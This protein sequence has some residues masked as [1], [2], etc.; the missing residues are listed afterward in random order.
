MTVQFTVLAEAFNGLSVG[1]EPREL[2][3]AISQAFSILSTESFGGG[4]TIINDLTDVNTPA[5]NNGDVLTWDSTPGEWVASPPA[6]AGVTSFAGRAGVVV[7]VQADYDGFFLTPAEGNAA[8]S[9]VGHTHTFASLTSKPTTI[10]GYGITD[11]NSLGDARWSLLGHVHA[12]ADITSGTI[13]TARLGSGTANATTFLRGDQTWAAPA[14]GV[15]D[16]DKGDIT[17]SGSGTVWTIDAGVVTYAKIQ[18]VSATDKLLGRSTAGAGV[19]EEIT[20]TA[21]GRALIDDA[22]ATAQRTTLGLLALATKNTVATGDI[23]N[24]AVTYAKIQNVTDVRLLGRS[25][26]SAGDCQEITV[27]AG[28]SLAAGALTST[29]VPEIT[30]INGNSGAAGADIT[31]QKLSANATANATTTVATVMTTTGLGTGTWNFKYVI[32][33]Q[34]AAATTGVDFAIQHTGTITK[35]VYSSWYVSSGGAAAVATADQ[36]TDNVANLVEGK[37]SRASNTKMGSTLGTD[38]AN[39]DML[40]IIEGTVVV[41]VSGSLLLRHAS[42]LAASTQVMAETSLELVKVG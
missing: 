41:T 39:S 33:Y 21:A 5:P 34:A 4:A 38:A 42:E 32:I 24:D 14:G 20:C 27:G 7:P 22:D 36:Q 3:D 12:A 40:L 29:V 11:F 1:G 31:L 19:V 37:S 9:A 26:G 13:A 28:L 2:Y 6:A 8:Y 23:D 25:A 30:R 16:G 17:V 18:N 35:I 15:S 10:G